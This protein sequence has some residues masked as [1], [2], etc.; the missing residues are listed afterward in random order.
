MAF[1]GWACSDASG[2]AT[3]PWWP[4]SARI[5][6]PSSS[7]FRRDM[8]TTA[9]APSEIWDAEP[10]V[11]VPSGANAGRSF[12]SDSAVVSG[13][14]PSSS[15][16]TSGSPLR[17]GISTGTISSSN[18]PSFIAAAARSCERAENSSWSCRLMP[19]RAL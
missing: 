16:T 11:I 13:R 8:T 12:A 18:R 3:K 4:T 9:A 6:A 14:T 7:A 15:L 1:A 2:P 10:A 17:C 5:G 19:S